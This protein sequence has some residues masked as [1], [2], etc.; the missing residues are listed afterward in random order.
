MTPMTLLAELSAGSTPPLPVLIQQ[1][2]NLLSQAKSRESK[3]IQA[4]GSAWPGLAY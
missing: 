2:Y 3:Q 4:L 1:A